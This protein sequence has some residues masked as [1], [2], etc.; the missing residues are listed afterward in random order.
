[1]KLVAGVAQSASLQVSSQPGERLVLPANT[2][3][4]SHPGIHSGT[5]CCGSNRWIV[6]NRQHLMW[7]CVINLRFLGTT[8]NASGLHFYPVWEAASL[9]EWLFNGGPYQPIVCHFFIVGSGAHAA[10]F[11]VADYRAWSL[12]GLERVL[13]HRHSVDIQSLN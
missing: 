7:T 10:L 4:S 8:S 5:A 9:D 12:P 3:S 2:N 11:L 13:A 1:V 6:A